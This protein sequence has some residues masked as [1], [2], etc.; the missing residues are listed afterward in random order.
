MDGFRDHGDAVKVVSKD[1][2][3]PR[4]QVFCQ[5]HTYFRLR[6]EQVSHVECVATLVDSVLSKEELEISAVFKVNW[7]HIRLIV[8]FDYLVVH[9]FFYV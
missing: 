3:E 1:V 5:E 7:E 6:R 2:G 4:Q 8:S 9:A